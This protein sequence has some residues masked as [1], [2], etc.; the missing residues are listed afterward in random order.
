[1]SHSTI[2]VLNH[3]ATLEWKLK[4]W[5]RDFETTPITL[6]DE[7]FCAEERHVSE[8]V[9]WD[10]GFLDGYHDSVSNMERDEVVNDF[11]HLADYL[12]DYASVYEYSTGK[13]MIKFTVEGVNKYVKDTFADIEKRL[14]TFESNKD[15]L[16]YWRLRKAVNGDPSG[17]YFYEDHTYFTV[18]EW[19]MALYDLFKTN[20]KDDYFVYYLD[21]ALDY[22]C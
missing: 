2:F 1:M 19:F 4:V 10:N 20:D 17:Y 12:K 11:K 3:P 13:F 8:E 21:D 22:H 6:D 5:N 16:N 18:T 9:F 15:G 7:A 14:K